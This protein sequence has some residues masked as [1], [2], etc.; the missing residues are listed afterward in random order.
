MRKLKNYAKL[1]KFCEKLITAYS[2]RPYV[3]PIYR[4][5]HRTFQMYPPLQSGLSN[6]NSPLSSVLQLICTSATCTTT[7]HLFL[8]SSRIMQH[9]CAKINH[10]QLENACVSE[11]SWQLVILKQNCIV[12]FM[13]TTHHSVFM[14]VFTVRLGKYKFSHWTEMN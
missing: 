12:W 14:T 9:H 13:P 8:Q 2:M 6:N 1:F 10:L 5:H 3:Q 4:K 11:L 7:E